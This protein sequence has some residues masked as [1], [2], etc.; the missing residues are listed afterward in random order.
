MALIEE[1]PLVSCEWLLEHLDDSDVVVVE[2][3]QLNGYETTRARY[4]AGHIPTALWIDWASELRNPECVG[5]LEQ[6]MFENLMAAKGI[7]DTDLVVLYSADNNIWSTS[8]Y[9]HFR[10]FGHARTS[11]L[12]GGRTR[13]ERLGYPMDSVFP[14]PPM[15]AYRS[16]GVDES[17]RAL[18]SDVLGSLTTSAF[19]DAREPEEYRGETFSPSDAPN[20]MGGQRAGHIPGAVNVPWRLAGNA[21]HTFKRLP[22]LREVFA[23][24]NF[25]AN[26]AVITYCWVGARSAYSWFVLRELMGLR[27]VRNYDGS[28]AEYGSSVGAPIEV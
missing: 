23:E 18:R 27:D 16:A 15:T 12:D 26:A 8:A 4:L 24:A 10:L 7:R 21:D 13:W 19:I 17:I 11:V 9:W 5:V 6:E 3:G 22:E 2:V 20:A 14:R 1:S 25:S 28:W